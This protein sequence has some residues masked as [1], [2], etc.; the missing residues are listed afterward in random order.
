MSKSARKFEVRQWSIDLKNLDLAAV[1]KS[2]L[3]WSKHSSLGSLPHCPIGR[4]LVSPYIQ[5]EPLLVQ[6]VSV[7]PCPNTVWHC[8]EP[9]SVFLDHT[10]VGTAGLLL[11]PPRAVSSPG[12]NQPRLL[13]LFTGQEL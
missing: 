2:A 5:S 1:F 4:E 9:G 13:S 10:P 6:L 12:L 11:G 3:Y 8:E 7:V